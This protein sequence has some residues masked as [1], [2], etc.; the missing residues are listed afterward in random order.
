MMDFPIKQKC[1]KC[2]K[3][4]PLDEYYEYNT[5]GNQVTHWCKVCIE[6]YIENTSVGAN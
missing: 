1:P 5:G 2:G 6:C 3:L 4:K